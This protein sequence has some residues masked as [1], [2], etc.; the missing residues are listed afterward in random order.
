MEYVR[1]VADIG[2]M[3]DVEDLSAVL[4]G[5]GLVG[6]TRIRSNELT[7]CIWPKGAAGNQEMLIESSDGKMLLMWLRAYAAGCAAA[8]RAPVTC[9]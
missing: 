3:G 4:G 7:V 1:N 2:K 6:V 5:L 9:G 8:P